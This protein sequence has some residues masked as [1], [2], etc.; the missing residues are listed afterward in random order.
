MRKVFFVLICFTTVTAVHAAGVGEFRGRNYLVGEWAAA[1]A[2]DYALQKDVR[3][4][5]IDA[6]ISNNRLYFIMPIRQVDLSS[7]LLQ[8]GFI[9]NGDR[10]ATWERNMFSVDII[11]RGPRRD[12]RELFPSR[13]SRRYALSYVQYGGT[14]TIFEIVTD[15]EMDRY[16]RELE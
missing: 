14:I 4:F 2:F 16:L 10:I 5:E 11:Y 1:I 3:D 15:V 12:V 9:Q 8:R 7:I 6:A 13:N